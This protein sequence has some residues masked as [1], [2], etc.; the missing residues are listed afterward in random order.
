MS[1]WYRFTADLARATGGNGLGIE[2]ESKNHGLGID[3]VNH[4]SLSMWHICARRL[5]GGMSSVV[6][7]S[8]VR[9]VTWGHKAFSTDYEMDV[10]GGQG[11][12]SRERDLR[13]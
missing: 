11:D 6:V 8:R 12:G 13:T 9:T 2:G 1:L 10:L 3:V 4:A 5:N 7:V